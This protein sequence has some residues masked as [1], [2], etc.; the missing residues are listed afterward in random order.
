MSEAFL[1]LSFDH[2]MRHSILLSSPSLPQKV[3][4]TYLLGA[5]L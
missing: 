5:I 4:D 2:S 1:Y 3:E